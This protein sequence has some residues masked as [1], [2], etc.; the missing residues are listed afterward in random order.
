MDG[1][2]VSPR[3]FQRQ[4][5]TCPSFDPAFLDAEDEDGARLYHGP[6]FSIVEPT[7]DTGDDALTS[8]MDEAKGVNSSL[9]V[10]G[11]WRYVW[12]T[13]HLCESLR[14]L[15]NWELEWCMEKV[16]LFIIRCQFLEES[17]M[18]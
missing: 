16:R 2:K 6:A 7:C 15:D 1:N 8:G 17:N 11:E 9:H 18:G 10:A 12:V 5:H 3:F 14:L 4:S 13:R